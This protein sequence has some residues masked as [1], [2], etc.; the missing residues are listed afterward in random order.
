MFPK[1]SC[2]KPL[3]SAHMNVF[4]LAHLDTLACLSHSHIIAL[5]PIPYLGQSVAVPIG[6]VDCTTG[7][8]YTRIFREQK[9]RTRPLP[10]YVRN[11]I[12]KSG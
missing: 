9:R 10:T 11:E 5:I 4:L 12:P 8:M 2:E 3:I 1:R 6:L 7:L